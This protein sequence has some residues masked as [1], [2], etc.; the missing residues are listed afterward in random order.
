MT[1]SHEEI[2]KLYNCIYNIE[3]AERF[4][5]AEMILEPCMTS[6]RLKAEIHLQGLAVSARAWRDLATLIGLDADTDLPDRE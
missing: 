6:D 4:L 5:L 3:D 2:T 1:I